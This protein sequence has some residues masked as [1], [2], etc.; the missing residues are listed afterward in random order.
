MPRPRSGTLFAMMTMSL[1]HLFQV[2]DEP[3]LRSHLAPKLS[4]YFAT[5]RSGIFFFDQLFGDRK[6]Q[7]MLNVGRC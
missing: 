6:L 7:A 3:D 1:Q 4:E 5:K 2:K